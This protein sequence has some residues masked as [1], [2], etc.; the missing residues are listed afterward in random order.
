MARAIQQEPLEDRHARAVA[1]TVAWA[2][3]AAD[4]G[5]YQ[6]ALSW[7]RVLEAVD[8]SLEPRLATLRDTWEMLVKRG[9]ADY[10]S[11]V[12]SSDRRIRRAA[13][14]SRR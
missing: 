7:L 5:N 2:L 8:G 4:G 12:L 10:R 13:S 11:R 1:Q 14:P 9:A 3:S 6:E